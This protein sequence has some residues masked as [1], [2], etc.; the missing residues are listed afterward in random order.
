MEYMQIEDTYSP[1][2]HRIQQNIKRRA[3]RPNEPVPPPPE[4]LT[5]YSTPPEELLKASQDTLDNL[6]AAADIKKGERLMIWVG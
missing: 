5:K 2:I 3:V 4:I 6:I 1:V